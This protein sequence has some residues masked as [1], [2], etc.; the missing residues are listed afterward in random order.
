MT[1][2]EI[3]AR[4]R[5]LLLPQ[6]R[7]CPQCNGIACRGEVPGMG[8]KGTGRGFINNVEAL[9]RVRL[10]LSVIHDVREPDTSLSLFGQDLALPVIAAPMTGVRYNMGGRISEG[11]YIEALVRGCHEAGMLPSLGDGESDELLNT[12]LRVLSEQQLPGLVFLKPWQN[13]AFRERL[14]AIEPRLVPALGTDLDACG[15]VAMN[16]HGRGV[17]PKT[18]TELRELTQASPVPFIMKGI[19][20][21]ADARAAHRAGASAIVVSN[22]GG[23]VLD[24]ARGT[25][26]VLPAIARELKGKVT[27]LVDGGI[28]DGV[29]VFKMLALGADAVLI[30]RPFA[31]WAFGG[32]ADG[33]RLFGESLRRELAGAMLLTGAAN[34]DEIS[35]EM[36][37][38][39]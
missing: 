36:I 8:G 9:G 5:E 14:A 7:V 30:G 31:T 22:H 20:T 17:Y 25:A 19:M 38:G 11:A 33:V 35:P 2:D 1:P 12:G 37:V 18:E 24:H 3:R 29:D 13:D 34:L 15:L 39:N 4:A 27:I 26:E 10:N 28:R 23:R 16:H 21:P 6:C 32:G